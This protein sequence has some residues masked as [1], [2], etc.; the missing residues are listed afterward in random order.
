MSLNRVNYVARTTPV[1]SSNLNDIQDAIIAL[2]DVDIGFHDIRRFKLTGITSL[3]KTFSGATGVTANHDLVVDG[4]ARVSPAE[5]MGSEWS[6]TCGSETITLSGT[7]S[8][9]T[10]TTVIVT[11]GIPDHEIVELS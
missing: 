8:G 7:F 4:F 11:L 6:V 1:S 3:P 5:S 10:S 9:S 2:E